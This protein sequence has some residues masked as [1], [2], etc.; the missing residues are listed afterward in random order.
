MPRAA[1]AR[2]LVESRRYKQLRKRVGRY[3]RR[4]RFFYR[5]RAFTPY[6]G[7][8]AGAATYVVSTSDKNVGRGLVVRGSRKEHRHLALALDALAAAGLDN[9]RHVLLDVGANIGT[10]TISALADQGF[11]RVLAFEPSPENF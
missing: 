4:N 11:A 5:A 1:S 8:D 6:L 7:A 9:R 10:T 3:R 2:R